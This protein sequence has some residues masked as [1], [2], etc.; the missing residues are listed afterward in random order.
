MTLLR[1][2]QMR[3]TLLAATSHALLI[4]LSTSA[5]AVSSMGEAQVLEK[6]SKPCFGLTADAFQGG[7]ISLNGI[8]V[9]NLSKK[10]VQEVWAVSL[11]QP[12]Q[13][14]P[15]VCFEYGG[16]VLNSESLQASILVPDQ[17]YEVFINARGERSGDSKRGYMAKFCLVASKDQPSI[18][19]VK[20]LKGSTTW[21]NNKCSQ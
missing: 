9:S 14:L 3:N 13:M 8:S 1:I 10:P 7:R 19:V 20:G 11:N 4:V 2:L 6:N 16:T 12:I 17:I 15:D 18:R 21:T 5:F